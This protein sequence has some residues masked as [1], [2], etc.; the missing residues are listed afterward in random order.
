MTLMVAMVVVRL[1]GCNM[2]GLFF[3]KRKA[4]IAMQRNASL[5]PRN[6]RLRGK[7]AEDRIIKSFHAGRGPDRSLSLALVRVLSPLALCSLRR[8]TALEFST[9]ERRS[10]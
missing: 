2:D 4:P 9:L 3:V 5:A 10:R 1:F 8:V 6:S 7:L